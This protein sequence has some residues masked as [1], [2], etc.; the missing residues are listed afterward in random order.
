MYASSYDLAEFAIRNNLPSERRKRFNKISY[1]TVW[2][3]SI[4]G[5]VFYVVFS[6]HFA[7][8]ADVTAMATFN[9]GML[10]VLASF[11]FIQTVLHSLSFFRICKVRK[12][13]SNPKNQPQLRLMQTAVAWFIACLLLISALEL[14]NLYMQGIYDKWALTT[15]ILTLIQY[16]FTLSV[17][18]VALIG[19]TPDFSLTTKVQ[20]DGNVLIVA[21]D[22]KGNEVF[23]LYLKEC[24]AKLKGGEQA[25]V[26]R[27]VP[28]DDQSSLDDVTS[29][30]E[31]AITPSAT[32][33]S[34]FVSTF[35]Q[36][37]PVKA[38]FS[39]NN[40]ERRSPM[41]KEQCFENG[42][43]GNA[44]VPPRSQR[45]RDSHSTPFGN[46]DYRTSNLIDSNN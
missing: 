13:L 1:V 30:G 46:G 31:S 8:K 28:I 41:W 10:G 19:V 17:Y 38:Q 21:I 42:L 22:S 26:G 18:F 34:D 9:F 40:D 45:H 5:W 32:S 36:R 39:I 2:F 29:N 23:K 11:M 27:F 43:Q 24:E 12:V 4:V 7:L 37:S 25:V 6:A 20:A 35:D 44:A 14:L 3:L 16:Y 15:N 33:K